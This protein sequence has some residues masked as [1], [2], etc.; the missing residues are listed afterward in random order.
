MTDEKPEEKTK[1]E[2]EEKAKAEAKAKE[3][4]KPISI[5]DEARAIR[6][7]I[8]KEKEELKAEREKLEK[9]QSENLLSGT[10]GGN[11]PVTPP[12]E[13]TPKDYNDRIDKEMSEGKHAD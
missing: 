3:A 2:A 7:E 1:R 6:D 4:E 13:E 12:K 5:V 8:K 9:V 11:V 10:A